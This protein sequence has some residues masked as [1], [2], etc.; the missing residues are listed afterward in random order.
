MRLCLTS[1]ALAAAVG[2]GLAGSAAA[3]VFTDTASENFD[4][5]AHMDIRS[6]EVSNT[7]TDITFKIT[8]GGSITPPNDW[9]KYL[10]G[11]DTS[12]ATGDPGSP[13][14]NPWG[15]N[16]NMAAKMD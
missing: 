16:I 6:V 10:V 13:V 7:A 3:A 12:G 1:C 14:G 8:L 2:I 4:G 5:N 11:I 15:R 9:G